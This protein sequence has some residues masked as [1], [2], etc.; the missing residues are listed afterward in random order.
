MQTKT[1]TLT[2][3]IF[4][5]S[6][7]AGFAQQTPCVKIESILVAACTSP[8]SPEGSNEMMRFR[9][10]DT[11]L[12][13][14]NMFITWGSGQY[15]WSGV[16]QNQNTANIVAAFN[17]TIQSCG[18]I[19]EPTN[20][21]L[22]ANSQVIIITGTATSTTANSF[23]ALSDTIYMIFHNATNP[24]GHFLNYNTN[25]GAGNA[26]TTTISFS[27]IPGCSSTATYLRSDLININGVTP[28]GNST[29]EE[30]GATVLFDE[31]MNPTYINNGCIASIDFISAN[32]NSPGILCQTADPINLNTLVT[33][34]PGGFWTGQGVTSSGTFNPAGLSGQIAIT[35]NVL[36]EAC[37]DTTTQTNIINVIEF[38]SADFNLP[39]TICENGQPLNLA[40]LVTGT[41]GGTFSGPSIFQSTF[42][43]AGNNGPVEITYTVG[44]GDCQSSN[45]QTIEVIVLPTPEL[46]ST[47]GNY[48]PGD[49]VQAVEI[50]N[51]GNA[52]GV[53]FGTPDLQ[54]PIA[55]GNSFTPAGTQNEDYY[56]ILSLAGCTS[57]PTTYFYNFYPI[58][59]IISADLPDEIEAP[60]NLEAFNESSN[61]ASCQWFLN[62]EP[63]QDVTGN[64]LSL[65]LEQTGDY[66]LK[67]VCQNDKECIDQDSIT[68]TIIDKTVLLEIPNV[69]TPNGDNVNDLFSFNA[70]GIK[71]MAGRIF[72]RWGKIVYEWEGLQ[73]YWD[74]KI[75][76]KE[77]PAGTYF[78]VVDTTDIFDESK[79]TKGTVTL[80]R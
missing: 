31:N 51:A 14:A 78:Y 79:Q 35:Y 2:L 5:F 57:E 61:A 72:N 36:N 26:Q 71:Q 62:G 80:V 44:S 69:F 68:F 30:P 13:T 70:Q 75:N 66:V 7:L 4:L 29:P 21:V 33:G 15:G 18:F 73:A 56:V 3:F 34:T 59:T 17:N 42:N 65:L 8:G 22:P 48:C 45:T 38:P 50:T 25:P 77:A 16:V 49:E 63:I 67:L 76:E 64:A 43:P 60:F 55:Q 20:G 32:W 54:V 23:A 39:E 9:I 11:D 37:G 40:D 41:T 28:T 46:S 47:E 74:G 19:K 10:G 53:W 24:G 58:E 6:A 12:N 52:S 1:A 27:N